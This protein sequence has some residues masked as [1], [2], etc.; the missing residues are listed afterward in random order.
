M[1]EGFCGRGNDLFI[2]ISFFL[3]LF[4][5]PLLRLQI[6]GGRD[7]I[8]IL[9]EYVMWNYLGASLVCCVIV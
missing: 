2:S 5:G 6:C 4:L 7:F 8:N 9:L 1:N 3:C